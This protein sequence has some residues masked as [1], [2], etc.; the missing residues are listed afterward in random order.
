MSTIFRLDSSIRA[1][2]S[3]TRAVATTLES[4]L[5]AALD[6]TTVIRRELGLTPLPSTV[7]ATSVFASYTPEEY[8]TAEQKDAIALATEL[9]DELEQ[10]DAYILAL[11][12]Y[13]LGVSQHVKAWVDV[14]LTEPRFSALSP[15]SSKTIAGRPA[16]FIIARG[17]GYGPGTPRDG[18]DHATGW[19]R[20]IFEDLWRLDVTIIE[21]EL[22]MADVNPAMAELRDLGAQ[23]LQNAHNMA[24]E[25][26][27]IL[28]EKLGNTVAES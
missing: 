3:V 18:W 6:G 2:G 24:R 16:Y 26:A 21:S 15:L 28:A 20:R 23:N 7:W 13:N 19:L 11:P 27:K 10:A 12:F 22:T 14:L 8:Q 17:G 9:A 5:V 25:Q 1:E 4:E